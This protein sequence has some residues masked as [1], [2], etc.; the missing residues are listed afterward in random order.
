MRGL[1]LLTLLNIGL[2]A[3]GR[4]GPAVVLVGTP[5]EDALLTKAEARE[6]VVVVVVAPEELELPEDGTLS[7]ARAANS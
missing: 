5:E 1:L 3:S 7:A 6:V 2:E 4:S